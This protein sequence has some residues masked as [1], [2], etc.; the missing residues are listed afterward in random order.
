MKIHEYQAKEILG[1]EGLPVQEGV[2]VESL[3]Q[4]L[5]AA[6]TLGTFSLVVKAQILA[7]GRGKGGGV[8]LV[9]SEEELK[10]AVE[11]ILG[12]ELSTYQT[13][14]QATVV[15]KLLIAKLADIE[16]EW[17]L[18]ITLD[19]EKGLPCIIFSTSGGV[20]IEELART[21]PEKIINLHF[22]PTEGPT[23]QQAS[24]L[25]S[26]QG[27]S[28]ELG[29]Q[30]TDIIFK[31]SKFFVEKDCSLVE[32]NP[33]IVNP[34]NKLLLLDAKINF[35]D[36]GLF[37]HKEILE[38]RD[39]SEEDPR[40]LEAQKYDLS[41][42]GLDGN[43]GCMVNGA[44]LAMATMDLIKLAGGEPANFLDVG[45]GAT[46]EKVAVAF[47]IILKD[48][49]VKAVLVN[50]F[51]GIMKCDVIAEGI[52]EALK[53][54]DMKVPLVVRLEGTNVDKGKELLKSS[55]ISIIAAEDLK[56]ASEKVVASIKE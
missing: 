42:V 17:Y 14:G 33:L 11:S 40:E 47:K 3:E 46:A 21:S 13:S 49:Q 55:N 45:G 37:R 48:P 41:Y 24:D 22:D 32:V 56:D 27:L 5:E 44:G 52:L 54:V 36:N 50:I 9:S 43:I 6:K 53:E 25:I 19:R 34:E 10:T 16:Q 23:K 8:K 31:L 30:L 7:G 35:D 2:A 15:K 28:E 26:S 29:S 12:K 20:E 39:E 51:G 1:Q 18:G 38:L 4:A